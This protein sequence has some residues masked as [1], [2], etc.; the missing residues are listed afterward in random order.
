ME[1][2]GKG[3]VKTKTLLACG[4]IGGPLFVIAFL[5]EGAIRADYNVLRHPVSSLALGEGGW[6]QIVNFIVTGLLML[7]FAVGLRRA[8][9]PRGGSSWH[10][11]TAGW[12]N[13]GAR[14][15]RWASGRAST[16]RRGCGTASPTSK[17]CWPTREQG[18][19]SESRCP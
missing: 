7:A 8:L 18:K 3:T 11:A 13:C 5:V 9:R 2:L 6:M 10:T 16:I 4:A 12:P 14:W 15:R 19:L 17:S 1:H